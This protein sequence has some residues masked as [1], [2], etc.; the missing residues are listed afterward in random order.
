MAFNFRPTKSQQILNKKKPLA[1][2][3]AA[4]HEYVMSSY[5]VGIILDPTKNNFKDIKIPRLVEQQIN[6]AGIKKALIS[7]LIPIELLDIKFGNGSGAGGSKMDAK[8]TAMQENATRFFC[9]RF[10]ETGR[11]PALADV[12]KIY[13]DVDDEWED[14]FSKQAVALKRCA[15]KKGYQGLLVAESGYSTVSQLQDLD[16]EGFSAVLVG[17]GLAKNPEMMEYFSK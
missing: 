12:S 9:E 6:L 13:P 2:E 17:E 7:A 8:A 11:P 1:E 3:A 14:T 4:V 5:G 15:D 10:I 16:N